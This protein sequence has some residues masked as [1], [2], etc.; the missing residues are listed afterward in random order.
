VPAEVVDE[1]GEPVRVTGRAVVTA[2][3][4]RVSIGGRPFRAVEAWAGPWPYDERWW[5]RSSHRRRARFQM[6]L[7][8]AGAHLFCVEGGRWWVEATYD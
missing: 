5:D 2:P 8:E 6:M 3:P 7:A 4:A 1:Q